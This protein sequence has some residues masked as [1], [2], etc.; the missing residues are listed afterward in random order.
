M[1]QLV[2]LSRYL[3]T[4]FNRQHEQNI[5]L[6]QYTVPMHTSKVYVSNLSRNIIKFPMAQI[7]V[8]YFGLTFV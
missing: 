1:T 3:N 7:N 8:E 4:N 5:S 2:F 6:K